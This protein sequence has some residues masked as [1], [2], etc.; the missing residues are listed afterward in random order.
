MPV[1]R[2]FTGFARLAV[3]L[4]PFHKGWAI[5]AS[6]CHAW[7]SL[8]LSLPR[9]INIYLFSNKTVLTHSNRSVACGSRAQGMGKWWVDGIR[10]FFKSG[11]RNFK[12]AS[13]VARK[14]Q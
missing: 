14:S 12:Y 10:I 11:F 6:L 3:Q 13:N 7:C 2:A 9:I 8:S 1:H 4:S 5:G